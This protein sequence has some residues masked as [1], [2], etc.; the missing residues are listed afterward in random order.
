MRAEL[1]LAAVIGRRF[2]FQVMLNLSASG[3]DELLR[4]LEAFIGAHL[5]R[6][7]DDADLNFEFSHGLMRDVLYQSMSKIRRRR[8][9]GQVA[10]VL[11]QLYGS[12]SEDWD[13]LIGEHLFQAGRNK[14]AVPHLLRAAR[15]AMRILA[16]VEAVNLYDRLL[17]VQS[18]LPTQEYLNIRIERA[19][20]LKLA[21][22]YSE[23]IAA[24]QEIMQG[25]HRHRLWACCELP[26]R[27]SLEYGRHSGRTRCVPDERGV[28]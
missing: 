23:T 15:A 25:S 12:V 22:R 26:W 14:E 1:E 10:D 2:A 19:E 21:C 3:E 17:S 6:E 8:V 16:T 9:H 7:I 11:L 4:Y 27:R 24:C 5:I 28:G 18:S 20:A 13:A